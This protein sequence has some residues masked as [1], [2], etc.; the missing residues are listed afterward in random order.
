MLL[1]RAQQ[2]LE[3]SDL[4]PEYFTPS[5][6]APHRAWLVAEAGLEAEAKAAI[7]RVVNE[8][9]ALLQEDEAP[10]GL[11]VSLLQA[12]LI[13]NDQPTV[14]LAAG[15]LGSLAHLSA[16]PGTLVCPGRLLGGAALLLGRPDEARERYRQALELSERIRNRPEVAL[17]RLELAELL[18]D[19]YPDDPST[20]SGQG[21]D[22]T[23]EHLDLA[24]TELRD[25]KMQPA[26]ERALSRREILKA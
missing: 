20:G 7:E 11:L 24:I 23:L 10:T 6:R 9:S 8:E 22:E 19:H 14:K 1:G 2:A 17:T 16:I 3:A 26:L 5:G 12:A 15:K 4:V 18:L 13:V 25:M 21:R